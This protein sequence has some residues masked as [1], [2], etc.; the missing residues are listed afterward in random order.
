LLHQKR[1]DLGRFVLEKGITLQGRVLDSQG[2]PVG[3]VWVN[4]EL[5]SGLAQQP[6]GM[7]VADQI[8][9]SALSSATGEFTLRPLPP[10]QYDMMI[11][12]YPRTGSKD[13]T[14]RPVPDV[15]LHQSVTLEQGK[16]TQSVEIRAVPHVVIEIQQLDSAG[17]PK[18]SHEIMLNGRK[19]ESGFYWTEG[20]P[21][22]NGKIVIKAPKGLTETELNLLANEHGA[23]RFRW[24][25][26]GRLN[27]DRKIHLGT[28]SSDVKN[29]FVIY[30]TSPIVLVR[31]VGEDGSPIKEFKPNVFYGRD[32]RTDRDEFRW[33]S[34]LTG[35][36]NFEKQQDGRWRSESLLPDESFILTI[37][38]DGYHPWSERFSLP[39]GAVK[40]LEVKLNK[41]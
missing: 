18:K 19:S 30:Y 41:R 27:N 12:D 26:K 17:K 36:V 40:E 13:R 3:N 10:G 38:A 28:L 9:R 37:E 20:R 2:K 6:I 16:T 22:A 23:T 14:R 39:E 35:D 4:A 33:I 15:F 32:R 5:R 1:G 8:S 25:Q 29:L 34:G 31:A 11:T 7:P 24:S 21:D